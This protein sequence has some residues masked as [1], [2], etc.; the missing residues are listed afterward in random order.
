MGTPCRLTGACG[1]DI[2]EVD[3]SS[4]TDLDT[5]LKRVFSP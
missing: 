5:G 2:V 1:L 4:E 3:D